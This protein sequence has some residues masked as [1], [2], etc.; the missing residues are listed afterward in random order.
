LQVARAAPQLLDLAV[1]RAGGQ[2]AVGPGA[3]AVLAD[4][5]GQVE[6]QRHRHHVVLLGQGYQGLA[7]LGLDVGGVDHRQPPHLEALRGDLAQ[8]GKGLGGD[9]LVVLVVG[10]ERPAE[11]RGNDLG[12]FEVLAGKAGF[13]RAGGA[14]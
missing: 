6:D 8:Q 3:V 5:F 7:R 10:D 13:A 14:D 1:D 4:A 2:L 11:I 12:G 9:G